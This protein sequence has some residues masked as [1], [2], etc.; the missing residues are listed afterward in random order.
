LAGNGFLLDQFLQDGVNKR[1]DI[2][3]GSHEN[4]ARLTLEVIDA[5]ADVFGSHG[6]VGV[7]ISP[8]SLYG[9]LLKYQQHLERAS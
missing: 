3:G 4:R 1:T 2:Y 9:K 6:K 8:L 5:V 7:R